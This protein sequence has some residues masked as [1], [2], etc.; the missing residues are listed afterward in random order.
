MIFRKSLIA[1]SLSASA[2]LS[3]FASAESY[4]LVTLQYPPYQ[5]EENGVVDGIVVRILNRAFEIAGHEIEIE[6]MPW[7]R[8]IKMAKEGEADAIF[9]AY[10]T[11]ERETFL[12]YSTVVVMEQVVSV[13]TQPDTNIG[14][15]GT[16]GS[17]ADVSLG[18]VSGLSYGATVDDAIAAGT[19]QQVD[20]ANTSEQNVTK[21][22]KGRIDALIMNRYNALHMASELG[23]AHTIKEADPEISSVPSYIA[24]SKAKN[25]QELRDAI[26]AALQQMIDSGE[27]QTLIDGYLAS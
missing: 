23:S 15:D 7:K 26:D 14:Y 13:F 6:V 18:L 21:L 11:A 24:F 1:A 16:M 4:S 17:L 3:S 20:Y 27:Y 19:F 25:H 9:T 22:I 12:D 10:K 8:A 2:L 5:Y